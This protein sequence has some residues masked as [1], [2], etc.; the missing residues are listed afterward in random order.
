VNDELTLRTI[1]LRTMVVHTVTYF[2]AGLTAF[3]LFDYAAAFAEPPLSLLMRQTDD[4]LVMAG[5]LFQPIRGLL[6]GLVFYLFRTRLFERREGWL[7]AWAMLAVVGIFS[8]FGP[9]PGSIEGFVYTTL[10]PAIQ[11]GGLVEVLAQSLLL[12]V[13]TVF[14]V[15]HPEKRWLTWGLWVLF[16]I[17]LVLPI[18]GL[19]ATQA[20]AP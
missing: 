15:R 18:L 9:A 20:G 6:F 17:V 16:V 7:A 5:V 10:P 12:A 19:V 4:P 14:W 2:V 1:A 13:L 11:F 8:T 3:T